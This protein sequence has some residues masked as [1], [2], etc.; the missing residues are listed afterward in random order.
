MEQQGGPKRIRSPTKQINKAKC[1]R[2]KGTRARAG[3]RSALTYSCDVGCCSGM[4]CYILAIE[5]SPGGFGSPGSREEATPSASSP[6]AICLTPRYGFTA[7]LI[8]AETSST[9]ASAETPAFFC[10]RSTPG[11]PHFS[12][13]LPA[14][15]FGFVSAGIR[16]RL[17]YTT[18]CCR[19]FVVAAAVALAFA[20]A[21][22]PP[23]TC[24]KGVSCQHS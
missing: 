20:V 1:T 18:R 19:S 23:S 17:P 14:S 6:N 9:F 2:P 15:T 13:V 24:Y 22:H 16:S 3:E 12:I 7:N 4:I 8:H 5:K 21:P 10:G 11:R